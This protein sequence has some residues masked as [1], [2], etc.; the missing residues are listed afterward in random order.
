MFDWSSWRVKSITIHENIWRTR[1]KDEYKNAS[2]YFNLTLVQTAEGFEQRN[3][4]LSK[5]LL[6]QTTLN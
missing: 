4:C 1:L 3:V 2:K 5:C 6:E